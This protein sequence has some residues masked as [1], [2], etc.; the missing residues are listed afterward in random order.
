MYMRE[1]GGAGLD[2]ADKTM[3]PWYTLM[4]GPTGLALTMEAWVK[5]QVARVSR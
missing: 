4:V 2:C 5:V 3:G 1:M